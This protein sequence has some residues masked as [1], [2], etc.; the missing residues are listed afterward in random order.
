METSQNTLLYHDDREAQILL[1]R[2][3]E[4]MVRDQALREKALE[5]IQSPEFNQ[6][7]KQRCN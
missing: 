2:I 7:D 1:R 4:K 5:L 3:R 6:K